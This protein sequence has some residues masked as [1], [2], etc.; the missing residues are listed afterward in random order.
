M[1][2]SEQLWLGLLV[3][4]TGGL[5]QPFRSIFIPW[6]LATTW[7]SPSQ[8][9]I[10]K[11]LHRC[12]LRSHRACNHFIFP[13]LMKRKLSILIIS[14][15][16]FA[17]L[18][19]DE[20]SLRGFVTQR[21]SRYYPIFSH[22]KRIL[23]RS[24]Q[25]LQFRIGAIPLF[26]SRICAATLNDTMSDCPPL[27][28]SE[29]TQRTLGISFNRSIQTFDIPIST[30]FGP[31]STTTEPCVSE[32]NPS[33]RAT[34]NRTGKH[35]WSIQ[36]C[37]S[38]SGWRTAAGKITSPMTVLARQIYWSSHTHKWFQIRTQCQDVLTSTSNVWM[39]NGP[40]Q[41][42]VNRMMISIS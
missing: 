39:S 26:A 40:L 19:D 13:C 30:G 15:R 14:P 18:F 2:G 6:K 42:Y 1:P 5:K 12:S 38:Q 10:S 27:R 17:T 8:S 32:R 24:I 7:F 28:F 37:A 33:S 11:T 34:E 4:A 41:D 16:G 20:I 9:R 31:T 35:N 36:C 25:S 29:G 22:R 23:L 21:W 3:G